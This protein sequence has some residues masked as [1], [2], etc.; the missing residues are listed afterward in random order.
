MNRFPL[1][2]KRAKAHGDPCSS[3]QRCGYA[4]CQRVGAIE[5]VPSANSLIRMDA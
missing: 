5:W 2:T 4:Q 1:P 3:I